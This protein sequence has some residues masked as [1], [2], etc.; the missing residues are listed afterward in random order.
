MKFALDFKKKLSRTEIV[1]LAASV[2]TL[3]VL[4]FYLA[5]HVRFAKEEG[6]FEN[7]PK[8]M[9]VFRDKNGNATSVPNPERIEPWMNFRYVNVVFRLPEEYLRDSLSIDDAKYP[10]VPI[11]KYAKKRGIDR[12]SFLR[13]LRRLVSEAQSANGK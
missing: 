7:R 9:D 10:N 8:I 3:A 5:T 11:G 2:M 12:E 13:E 6:L 1:I 4:F